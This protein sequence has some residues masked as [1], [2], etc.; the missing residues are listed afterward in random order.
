ML[1]VGRNATRLYTNKVVLQNLE[2]SHIESLD[3]STRHRLAYPVHASG[4]PL[5]YEEIKRI[6]EA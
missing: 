1:E 2:V 6:S 5:E 3:S 4:S